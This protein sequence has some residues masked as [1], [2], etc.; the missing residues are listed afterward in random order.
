MQMETWF[1]ME[2]HAIMLNMYFLIT[3]QK[4]MNLYAKVT[5]LCGEKIIS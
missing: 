1:S 2:L 5:K 3:F 4:E